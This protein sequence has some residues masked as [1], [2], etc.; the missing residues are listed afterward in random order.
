MLR[1]IPRTVT[2]A[3]H[4][5]RTV[6][7]LNREPFLTAVLGRAATFRQLGCVAEARLAS[8]PRGRQDL[9]ARLPLA[10]GTTLTSGPGMESEP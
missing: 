1:A 9:A 10:V 2:A 5:A 3:A 8:T 4:T 6:Y 7:H